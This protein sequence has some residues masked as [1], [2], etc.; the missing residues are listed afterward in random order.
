MK[1]YIPVK[2]SSAGNTTNHLMLKRKSKSEIERIRNEKIN[3]LTYPIVFSVSFFSLFLFTFKTGLPPNVIPIP[4]PNTWGETLR[5][6]PFMIIASAVVFLGTFMVQK[7]TK[8]IFFEKTTYICMKCE[9]VFEK[10]D[11]TECE[12]GGEIVLIDEVDFI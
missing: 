4:E 11:K 1:R 6:L 10:K 5:A 9:D 3:S 7:L 8:K 12:C 2:S